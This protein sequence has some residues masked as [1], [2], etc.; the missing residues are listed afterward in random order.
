MSIFEG[1]GCAYLT[2]QNI[3]EYKLSIMMFFSIFHIYNFRL[4]ETKMLKRSL[5]LF[6]LFLSS[7]LL[8]SQGFLN[9]K[10]NDRYFT[11]NAG[12]GQSAYFGELNH[13]FQLEEGLSHYNIGLEARLLNHISART[14]F[15]LYKI[16]GKDSDANDS[17]FFQQRNLS[18]KSTNF[19]ANLQ[20]QFY[21]FPYND[22]YHKR[23]PI[24][25]FLAA[26]VGFTTLNPKTS[27]SGS[28]VKLRKLRTEG[29]D[30]GP[31][32]M[33]I[34]VG[35]GAKIKISQF[36][37][38][39]IEAS[40]RFTFED[41]ID[42]VSTVFTGSFESELAGILSNRRGEVD[43][44]NQDAFDQL[45]VGQPRGDDS[46]NDKYFG[47]AIKVEYYLPGNLFSNKSGNVSK[48]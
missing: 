47:F 18:F 25:P 24:E 7:G 19:E 48:N 21:F 17:S 6:T 36:V 28:D 46:N 20:L 12:I 15:I 29:V 38:L 9:N 23:R 13:R 37:N 32:T 33:V 41:Y 16:S 5:L 8:R 40:Y 31:I 4:I 2:K 11:V 45:V 22:I 39:I 43:V 27:F 42:D 1:N 10:Y 14:E 34:P 26:G 30:Y 44:L 3:E 35:L